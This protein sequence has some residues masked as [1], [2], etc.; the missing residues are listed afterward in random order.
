M[1]ADYIPE[2]SY[3]PD[4]HAATTAYPEQ[5]AGRKGG[6]EPL[7]KTAFN[8]HYKQ[9][10]AVVAAGTAAGGE[11]GCECPSSS[12]QPRQVD[13]AAAAAPARTNGGVNAGAVAGQER[14]AAPRAQPAKKTPVEMRA[15]AVFRA[16]EKLLEQGAE[17]E[18][19]LWAV[20]RIMSGEEFAQVAEER[21][22][23]GLCG[24]PL[25]SSPA[26]CQPTGSAKYKIDLTHQ[27]VY[28]REGPALFCS[29]DCETAVRTF[30]SR[31]GPESAAQHRFELLLHQ[32]R[33]QPRGQQAQQSSEVPVQQAAVDAFGQQ[34]RQLPGEQQVSQQ[35]N[36]GLPAVA[37]TAAAPALAPLSCHPPSAPAALTDRASSRQPGSPVMVADGLAKGKIRWDHGQ[38][39]MQWTPNRSPAAPA[40]P[41]A[42]A[43]RVSG[44]RAAPVPGFQA[45]NGNGGSSSSSVA[46]VTEGLSGSSSDSNRNQKGSVGSGGVGSG[47]RGV[48]KKKPEFA[49]GT[50]KIPIMLSEVKERDPLMVAADTAQS[51]QADVA[52]AA[53]GPRRVTFSAA[54][55]VGPRAVEGY[56][57][58]SGKSQFKQIQRESEGAALEQ[59]RERR[60]RVRFSDE[61]GGSLEMPSAAELAA[62]AAATAAPA[63]AAGRQGGMAGAGADGSQALAASEGE[64]QPS[65]AAA[66][67]A[68][69]VGEAGT[70]GTQHLAADAAVV[71]RDAGGSASGLA[72][73]STAG[74]GAAAAPVSDAGTPAVLVFDVDDPE[75]P[76]EAGDAASLAAHFGRLRVVEGEAAGG[77]L[78]AGDGINTNAPNGLV[79]PAPSTPSPDQTQQP[80]RG[81]QA[82]QQSQQAQQASL[83]EAVTRQMQASMRK[84]F[85]RLSATLPAELDASVEADLASDSD[86]ADSAGWSS[87]EE[88]EGGLVASS[89]DDEVA[90]GRRRSAYRMTLSFFGT[91]FTHLESWITDATLEHLATPPRAGAG[92]TAAAASPPSAHSAQIEAVLTRFLATA[93]PAV[94]QQL[95]IAVPR[96]EV[97]RQLSELLHTMRFSGPL[98]PFKG[99][100]WQLVTVILLKALSLERSPSLRAAFETRE[101]IHRLN[102]ALAGFSFTIEEFCAVL[103]L[104]CPVE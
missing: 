76:L 72:Q 61:E 100:Q 49:A 7:L 57:P 27:L 92:A 102:K 28:E 56:V 2:L 55:R 99:P 60:R 13:A 37:V 34:Q 35:R 97:E 16:L 83:E 3:D 75:S 90:G 85:P 70:A 9:H 20:A 77:G 38:S 62:T 25:C 89:D 64:A 69:N 96:G 53:A 86:D 4:G 10:V 21:Y 101:G 88:E 22:L 84:L 74:A 17:S 43:G 52:Q 30:A 65:G 59:E 80:Q 94:V 11:A 26:P 33:Q 47:P 44:A 45:A 63:M 48:L 46:G 51:L 41:R 42:A 82:Q 104:L 6:S 1:T 79:P 31:L 73:P 58:R 66:A 67:A 87:S 68:A 81:Q 71:D 15:K 18:A 93:L 36:G 98:P 32:A 103:E 40:Q 50:T 8:G 24:N 54:S 78:A 23:A 12:Q 29:S 14:K 19:Q 91:L 39:A 95:G 5:L